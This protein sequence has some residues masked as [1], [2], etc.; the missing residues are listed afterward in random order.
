MNWYDTDGDGVGDVLGVDAE[1]DGYAETVLADADGDGIVDALL[2]DST[3]DGIADEFAV[4]TDRDGVFDTFFVDRNQNGLVEATGLDADGDG[5][6]DV[7]SDD[8]NENGIDDRSETFPSPGPAGPGPSSTDAAVPLFPD[9][10]TSFV[11]AVSLPADPFVTDDDPFDDD[12]GPFGEDH[13]PYSSET[14]DS[15]GDLVA[16]AFDRNPTAD[17]EG[18]FRAEED[19]YPDEDG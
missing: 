14:H 9:G 8:G 2:H 7:V 13:G 12:A 5:L 18:Y 4:D 6:L 16:D 11:E 15:D 17:E 3:L 1:C 10:G 19:R